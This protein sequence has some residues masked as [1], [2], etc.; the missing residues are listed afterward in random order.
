MLVQT[1]S[2]KIQQLNASE[3]SRVAFALYTRDMDAVLLQD[4]R[5]Q[6]MDTKQ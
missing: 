2:K 4:E 6:S 1:A 3:R 5:T